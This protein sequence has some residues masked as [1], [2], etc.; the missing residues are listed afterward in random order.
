[1]PSVTLVGSIEA[2]IRRNSAVAALQ[3]ILVFERMTQ[4]QQ[5]PVDRYDS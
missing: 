1:M 4:A 2:S 5:Q 3:D